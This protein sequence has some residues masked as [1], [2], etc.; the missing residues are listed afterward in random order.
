LLRVAHVVQALHSRSGEV[1]AGKEPTRGGGGVVAV[2]LRPLP[3]FCH[4]G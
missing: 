1:F 3:R 2:L 4:T